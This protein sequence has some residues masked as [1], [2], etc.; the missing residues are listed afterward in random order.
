MPN[1]RETLHVGEPLAPGQAH[2]AWGAGCGLADI[3][4]PTDRAVQIH[5]QLLVSCGN[6]AQPAVFA[7]PRD[8]EV[9]AQSTLSFGL[10]LTCEEESSLGLGPAAVEPTGDA[11]GYVF[12]PVLNEATRLANLNAALILSGAQTVDPDDLRWEASPQVAAV[13]LPSGEPVYIGLSLEEHAGPIAEAIA[14]GLI[15]DPGIGKPVPPP[16]EEEFGTGHTTPVP[17]ATKRSYRWTA[18]H[19]GRLALASAR[20]RIGRHGGQRRGITPRIR[21][22]RPLRRWRGGKPRRHVSASRRRR[23]L[24]TTRTIPTPWLGLQPQGHAPAHGQRGR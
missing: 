20:D 7:Q 19:L 14:A 22:R 5:A 10:G 4:N 21:G 12:R 18:R 23:G 17:N 3:E 13:E 9:P 11:G 1:A 6:G 8:V 2:V 15:D 16:D 24:K